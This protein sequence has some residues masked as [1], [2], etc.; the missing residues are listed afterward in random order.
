MGE[1]LIKMLYKKY[2]PM[3]LSYRRD[4]RKEE[5]EREFP[6]NTLF[7]RD[8]KVIVKHSNYLILSVKPVQMKE[9]CQEINFLPED[10]PIISA[11]AAIPLDLLHKWLPNNRNIIRCM[12]NIPC[13]S[14]VVLLH[15]IRRVL[16]LK[17]L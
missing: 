9:V 3:N 14:G 1:H 11:A 13:I 8:N 17:I 12:P 4:E 6:I 7:S 15:I 16:R 5:L 10:F 2:R